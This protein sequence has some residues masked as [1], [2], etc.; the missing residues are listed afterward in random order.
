MW[1]D[2]LISHH[3]ALL[4]CVCTAVK[5]PVWGETDTSEHYAT[6]KVILEELNATFH[7]VHSHLAEEEMV[8]RQHG[9]VGNKTKGKT[10]LLL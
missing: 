8:K 7:F 9:F 5:D 1:L 2:Y 6:I 3:Q 4:Q 10:L